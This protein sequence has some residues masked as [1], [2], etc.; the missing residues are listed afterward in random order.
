[1]GGYEDSVEGTVDAA[2]A[3]SRPRPIADIERTV[4][5]ALGAHRLLAVRVSSTLR[6]HPDRFIEIAPRVWVRRNDGPDA[7]VRSSL[8][9]HPLAGGAATAV[10]PGGD[11]GLTA[12]T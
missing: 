2:L 11:Q 9:R 12:R 5:R 7:G 10:V 3:D 8:P 4:R 6:S 1:M